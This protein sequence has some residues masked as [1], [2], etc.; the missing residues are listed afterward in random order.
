MNTQCTLKQMEFHAFGRR[1][2]VGRFDG[3]Q[4]SSDGGGLLLREAEM[5]TGI[6]SR[7]AQQFIDHRHADLIEH[8]VPELVSQRVLGIALGHEDLNDHVCLT[9]L[10]NRRRFGW[11]LLF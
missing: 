9:M 1:A 8:S 11:V 4:I 5:R 10:G 6:L 3:G 2:V 7:L